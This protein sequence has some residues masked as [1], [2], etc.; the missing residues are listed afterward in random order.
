ML[1]AYYKQAGEKG[2]NNKW[3]RFGTNSQN[4]CYMYY[5]ILLKSSVNTDKNITWEEILKF[6]FG[7]V[8]GQCMIWNLMVMLIVYRL[9]IWLWDAFAVTNYRDAICTL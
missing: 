2:E 6:V 4:E 1:F 9:R 5:Q 3:I 7:N 8:N